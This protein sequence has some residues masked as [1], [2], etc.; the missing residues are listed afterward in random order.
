MRARVPFP[1]G[2][3]LP[4]A[5]LALLCTLATPSG[6]SDFDTELNAQ[7]VPV[8]SIIGWDPLG[9]PVV[10]GTRSVQRLPSQLTGAP[11]A[12]ASLPQGTRAYD[13][14]PSVIRSDARDT[15]RVEVNVNGPVS[16]VRLKV[17]STLL[18]Q[19]GSPNILLRDD[20]LGEDRV[21]GDFIFTSEPLRHNS[22]LYGQPGFFRGDTNSPFGLG[23]TTLGELRI[24]ETNGVTNQFLVSPSVGLLQTNIITT[25]VVSLSSD[26]QAAPH[27]VNIRGSQRLSQQFIRYFSTPIQDLTKELYSVL[28]DAYDFL[29]FFSIDH[30]E[31][32]PWLDRDNFTAGIH[33]SVQIKFTGTGQGLYNTSSF[34]GSTGRLQGINVLD[35]LERGLYSQNATHELLHQWSSYLN[36]GL[37][38]NEDYG[39]YSFRSSVGSLLGGA[40]WLENSNGTF[41]VDCNEGAGGAHE[42][43][44]LDKYMMGLIPGSQVPTLRAFSSSITSL[45]C[46]GVVSNVALTVSITNIQQAQGIRSPDPATAQRDFSIGFVAESRDRLLTPVEITFYEKLAEQYTRPQLPQDPPPYLSFNWAPVGKFFGEGTVWTSHHPSLLAATLGFQKLTSPQYRVSGKGFP[47]QLYAIERSSDLKTWASVATLTAGTNGIFETTNTISNSSHFFR[48][49]WH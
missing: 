14:I 25:P 32:L 43:C 44:P 42:A 26:I 38:L 16:E 24:V 5:A 9:I 48:A 1:R 21:P 27:F 36:S 23:F 41:T 6:A 19:S 18:A 49:R 22:S 20:G 28:P 13:V 2:L 45:P 15:C 30:L 40:R 12:S 46:N 37:G 11:K 31:R 4:F 33:S 7:G 47:G 3:K 34:Y 10:C 35:T 39:H 17:S 8:S 29:F